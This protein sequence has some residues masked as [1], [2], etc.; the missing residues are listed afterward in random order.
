M[1]MISDENDDLLLKTHAMKEAWH[2]VMYKWCMCDIVVMIQCVC[3]LCTLLIHLSVSA[4]TGHTLC[5]GSF[6]LSSVSKHTTA[7]R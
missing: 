2:D 5:L 4:L 7:S 3:L 1:E 6:A